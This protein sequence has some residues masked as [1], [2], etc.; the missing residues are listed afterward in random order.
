MRVQ[1]IICERNK[2]GLLLRF[3]S[4]GVKIFNKSYFVSTVQF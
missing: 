2:K 1:N 4:S 3:K